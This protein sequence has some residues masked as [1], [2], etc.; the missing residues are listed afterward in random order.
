MK[1]KITLKYT[2]QATKKVGGRLEYFL[3]R[4]E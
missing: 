1:N 3:G 4:E 2:I